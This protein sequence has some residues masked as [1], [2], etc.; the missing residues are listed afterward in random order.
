MQQ[1]HAASP[2]TGTLLAWQFRRKLQRLVQVIET[3][4]HGNL[5]IPNCKKILSRSIHGPE[6][7]GRR[8]WARLAGGTP[9][10]THVVVGAARYFLDCN[11]FLVGE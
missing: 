6:M 9:S 2:D 11:L 7:P 10:C 3:L 4:Q 1:L 8:R 5:R